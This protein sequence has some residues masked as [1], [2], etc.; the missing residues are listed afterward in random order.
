MY[1]CQCVL[2]CSALCVCL[3]ASGI[4]VDFYSSN[5]NSTS[6]SNASGWPRDRP[7]TLQGNG[8]Q[9]LPYIWLYPCCSNYLLDCPLDWPF[10]FLLNWCLYRLHMILPRE[11]ASIHYLIFYMRNTL[12]QIYY[13]NEHMH[14]HTCLHA[15]SQQCQDVSWSMP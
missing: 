10:D 13:I 9:L 15:T 8:K 1:T 7:T 4:F 14:T 3:S 5:I 12:Y 11:F 2:N 6:V